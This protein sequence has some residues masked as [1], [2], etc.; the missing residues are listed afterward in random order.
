MFLFSFAILRTISILIFHAEFSPSILFEFTPLFLLP[1]VDLG[2]LLTITVILLSAEVYLHW[3]ENK[4]KLSYSLVPSIIILS[5]IGVST[6]IKPILIEYIHYYFL[7]IFLIISFLCDYHKIL[8]YDEIEKERK[9]EKERIFVPISR[10]KEELRKLSDEL[11]EK[12]KNLA[13]FE[14]EI[15]LKNE[16]VEKSIKSLK[17]KDDELKKR[18]LRLSRAEQEL[19]D[20]HIFDMIT[21]ED[22][23]K[24]T[25]YVA[26][27]TLLF[28]REYLKSMNIDTSKIDEH[29]KKRNNKLIFE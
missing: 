27:D 9:A 14:A 10:G 20:T 15:N 26:H 29:I 13:K 7:F 11:S 21:I 28:I 19:T 4:Q 23:Y 1:N 24:D 22:M 18:E 16:I 2:F 17:L 8:I 3:F 6:G 12:D 25:A 5:G